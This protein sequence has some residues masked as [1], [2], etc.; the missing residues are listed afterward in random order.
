MMMMNQNQ[1]LDFS[2]LFQMNPSN[3]ESE[4]LKM[5]R[6]I[7]NT[8]TTTPTKNSSEINEINELKELINSQN[9][10]IL[11]L[12]MEVELLRSSQTKMN[13]N[14]NVKEL[15]K[16]VEETITPTNK[17][18]QEL[19]NRIQNNVRN[20]LSRINL[21]LKELL[22]PIVKNVNQKVVE[23]KVEKP[24][25]KVSTSTP[26]NNSQISTK[27]DNLTKVDNKGISKSQSN[28]NSQKL[29]S[30]SKELKSNRLDGVK[31]Y[32]GVDYFNKDLNNILEKLFLNNSLNLIEIEK[33]IEY[34]KDNNNWKIIFSK[35]KKLL[36]ITRSK[37][38]WWI[39]RNPSQ[40]YYEKYM[41]TPTY[42][43]RDNF[44]KYLIKL[45]SIKLSEYK[46]WIDK[47]HNLK[48]GDS[49][50]IKTINNKELFIL[51]NEKG[52]YVNKESLPSN[53]FKGELIKLNNDPLTIIS[54]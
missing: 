53:K 37:F 34:F 5:V 27:V 3:Q 36:T 43:T 11:E 45:G 7:I 1:N 44:L 19:E 21:E 13:E 29:D 24:Q 9:K 40:V 18:I 12:R 42:Y 54:K 15:P 47:L 35:D 49:I 50:P 10:L 41:G 52:Y 31:I 51:V 2:K 28:T 46:L 30:N 22:L 14:K 6:N 17:M 20:E 48:E 16:I 39:N 8:T 26:I 32:G 38:G 23:E 33:V 25:S 4:L